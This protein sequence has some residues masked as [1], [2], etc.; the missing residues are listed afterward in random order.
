[1][2]SA[3]ATAAPGG[4]L[5]TIV[6]DYR[7]GLKNLF[8][9]PREI[10]ISFLV[11]VL[12][13]L[14]YFSS[15]LVL[16]PFFTQAMGFSDV[17][18]GTIFGIFSASMSFFMLF[19]GFIADSLGIKRALI[20]GLLIALVGRLG[21]TF[22]TNIWF[23]FPGLF[24]LSI[25]FAYMI[26]LLAAAVKIFSNKKAQKFAFSWYYVVMN[27]GSLA[28]GLVLDPIRAKYTEVTQFHILAMDLMVRPTQIIFLVG[29]LATLVSLVLVIF[30]I[31]GRIPKEDFNEE[32]EET[33][34]AVTAEAKAPAAEGPKEKESAWKIMREVTREKRFWI[35]ITFIGLLV[36]VKMIFQYNHS[37]YPLYMERIGLKEWTGKLYSINPFI[38]ILLVPVMTAITGRMKAYNVIMI[39]SFIAAGSVFF[40]GLGE[41]IAMIVLFQVVL[42]FGEA[43]YS[44]RIYDYTA[45]IAPPGR[46]ASY[47]AYSKAPMFFA[48]VAA[49]PITGILLANLCPGEGPRNTELMWVIVGI[50]T[51]VSPI[52]LL[53]GRKWLDVQS[54]VREDRV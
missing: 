46:E 10:W 53:L 6:D 14:C 41:S 15:V 5:K 17:K 29:V 30:F 4:A 43:I 19:V 12:E 3:E 24:F 54:R 8:T 33:A 23:V 28:A 11:K 25:G 18:A 27:V 22:T 9:C 31:R 47:M 1:M 38:I 21:I 42:S 36:L 16:M 7:N 32:E 35:F 51:M 52:M 45:S 13:S 39:G 26:P 20:V 50:S 49:G 40:M 44:P 37:L 48:K 2:T 34:G